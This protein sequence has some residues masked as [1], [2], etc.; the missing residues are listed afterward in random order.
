ME[1]PPMLLPRFDPPAFLDD[2]NAQQRQAWSD[3][4]S[5]TFDEQMAGAPGHHFYDP[6]RTD[7][8]ADAQTAVITWTAFPRSVAVDATSDPDRWQTADGTRDVQDE[9]CEWSVTRDGAGKVLRV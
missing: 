9:Y 1:T 5:Q 3:F 4:I 6:M 7:T 2:L 8:A